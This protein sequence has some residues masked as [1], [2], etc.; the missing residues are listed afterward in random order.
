MAFNHH[1]F[2]M[3]TFERP[4]CVTRWP[5]LGLVEWLVFELLIL[6]PLPPCTGIT[7][8]G[9]H[10]VCVALGIRPRSVIHLVTYFHGPY[11]RD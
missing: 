1:I 10:P 6:L 9:K 3:V 7:G 5:Q 11:C 8:V 4:M 2:N